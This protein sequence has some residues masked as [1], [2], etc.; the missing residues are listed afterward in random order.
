M[1]VQRSKDLHPDIQSDGCALMS[2]AFFVNQYTLKDMLPEHINE[3]YEDGLETGFMKR[4]SYV[5]DWGRMFDELGMQVQYLG[6]K[7]PEWKPA[8][9]EIEILLFHY[10]PRNWHHFVCGDGQGRVTYDPWGSAGKDFPGAKT[11]ALG[12]IVGKRGFRVM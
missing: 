11:V 10:A 12:S 8:D 5:N 6:H 2:A 1:I 9:D 4:R 3:V 7:E